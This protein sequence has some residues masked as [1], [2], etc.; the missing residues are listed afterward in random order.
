[1]TDD[2]IIQAF[3]QTGSSGKA[4]KF[5]GIS[6]QTVACRLKRLGIKLQIQPTTSDRPITVTEAAWLAGF[7][8]G[9]G[10]FG[11][12]S[13]AG[14]HRLRAKVDN[15]NRESIE[16]VKE[17]ING[18]VLKCRKL[19]SQ[20]KQWQDCFVLQIEGKALR[21]LLRAI[22]P[23]AVVKREQVRLCDEYLNIAGCGQIE[24]EARTRIKIALQECARNGFKRKL[25]NGSS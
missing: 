25:A 24:R 1:M 7:L 9:E 17:I 16:R 12:V 22:R 23:Y 8:D 2:A 5:L 21:R 15:T 3:R 6:R 13:K 4:A 10:W 11:V 14:Y 18:G 19:S 20:N